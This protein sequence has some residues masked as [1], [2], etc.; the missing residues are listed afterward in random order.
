M[1]ANI[2]TKSLGLVLFAT[3][4][5]VFKGLRQAEVTGILGTNVTLHFTFDDT[6]I[7]NNSHFAV[8]RPGM[9][10]IAECS[11]N[12]GCSGGVVLDIHQ[13]SSVQYH[14]TKLQQDHC[15]IYWASLFINSG[16][17]KESN[18]VQVFVQ[19]ENSSNTVSPLQTNITTLTKDSGSSS[20]SFYHIITILVVVLLAAVLLLLIWCLVRDKDKE[21][22]Q[23]QNSNPTVQGRVEG[24]YSAAPPSLIYSVLDFAQRPS[25][26]LDI[27]PND[28]E[29]ANVSYLP[30]KR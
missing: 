1:V 20:F 6:V 14:I 17:P 7:N 9:K 18:K 13:N 26:V 2:V 24:S 30:E 12:K 28:T 8:Y 19:K 5:V 29:Y 3:A 11:K 22:P 21:Q 23:Q 4:H 15:G 16:P 10:K 27:D 25:A